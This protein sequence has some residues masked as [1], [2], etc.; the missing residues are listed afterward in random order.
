MTNESTPTELLRFGPVL[1]DRLSALEDA[2]CD[3]IDDMSI[4]EIKEELR[5]AGIDTAPAISKLQAMI[6]SKKAEVKQ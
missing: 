2:T 4:E 3:S 6:E 5:Q 1:F